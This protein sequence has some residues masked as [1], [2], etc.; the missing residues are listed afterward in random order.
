[1]PEAT[2]TLIPIKADIRDRELLKEIFG[3]Y[4]PDA[5][6]HLAA[7]HHIPT[8][9][10]EPNLAFDVNVMGTQSVI[11]A[12]QAAGTSN[13]LM[14]SSGAVYQWEEG[15]LRE[16]SSPTGATD[17][18]SITKLS[19]EYQV[20]GW[21]ERIGARAH[22]IRLFNTIGSGDPNG[23]LIPDV[24]SQM[25]SDAISPVIALG[26]TAPKRDYIYVDDVAAGF[27]AALTNLPKGSNRE[28]FNLCTG[29]ELS[30][31]ELV[32]LMGDILGKSVQ[33][34]SDP[35]RVRKIDR[36]HQVGDPT[37]LQAQTGWSPRWTVRQSLVQ[38][39]QDLQHPVL[40]KS[41]A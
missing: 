37:K 2:A 34:V 15:L 18:Y 21:A 26:N 10:R 19:N 38:I 3:Q 6:L 11:E 8:C 16:D 13:L 24:L 31:A 5:V 17:V 29:Q 4:R 36:L 39:I 41:V 28:V 7:V 32:A 27:V 25:A 9:E 23:H 35:S 22:C 30:V 20:G 14:A 33:I 12:A 40:S 1:M